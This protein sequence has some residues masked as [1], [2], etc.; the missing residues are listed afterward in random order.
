VDWPSLARSL[1]ERSEPKQELIRRLL[2]VRDGFGG[3]MPVDAPDDVVAFQRGP[4]WLVVV[5]LRRGATKSH[6]RAA[7]RRDLLPEYPVGLYHGT[8]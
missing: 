1:R 4:D 7:H 5:P 6:A 2:E 8:A 3:Y